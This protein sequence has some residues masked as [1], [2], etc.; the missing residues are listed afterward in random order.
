MN[1]PWHALSSEPVSW[2]PGLGD[3]VVAGFCQRV[4]QRFR[5]SLTGCLRQSLGARCQ[6]CNRVKPRSTGPGLIC[7]DCRVALPP[8]TAGCCPRCGQPFGW[9][10]ERHLCLECRHTKR[11][12]EGFAVHGVY[13]GALR[14]LL[15]SFKFRGDLGLAGLLQELLCQAHAR[16]LSA[17]VPHGVVPVPLHPARLRQRGY[18]QSLEMVRRLARQLKA[19]LMPDVLRRTRHTRPQQGL[20]R[21]EREA[22]LKGAFAADSTRVAGKH[23]LLVDDVYTTGSTVSRCAG[24]LRRFGADRVDV[25]VLA[26]AR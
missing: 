12:W 17:S 7:R 6:A 11:P 15:L 14:E 26:R 23:L 10:S 9:G 2:L 1:R 5:G 22:N 13:E 18:N 16:S 3:G 20:S 24:T 21:K 19:P 8:L 4:V 25:L